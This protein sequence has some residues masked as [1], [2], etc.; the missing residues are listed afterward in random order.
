MIWIRLNRN[1][2]TAS[3]TEA[4]RN[5]EQDGSTANAACATSASGAR[6]INLN[7]NDIMELN[8]DDVILY[9]GLVGVPK[10]CAS[11]ASMIPDDLGVAQNRRA[12]CNNQFNKHNY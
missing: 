2:K 8:K 10:K 4:R 11:G 5:A 7:K 3:T 9:R 6:S 1:P 12:L